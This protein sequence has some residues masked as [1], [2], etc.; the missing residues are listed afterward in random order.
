[1]RM[2]V[3]LGLGAALTVVL[4]MLACAAEQEPAGDSAESKVLARVGDEVITEAD[5]EAS[6][7]ALPR[8]QQA[9]FGSALGRRRF[10][11]QLVD[12]KLI[13]VGAAD[14]GLDQDETLQRRITA[15]RESLLRQAYHNYM[16]AAL[17]QP[18]EEDLRA[19][20]E[21]HRDEFRVLA[22]VN[23]S[24]IQCATREDAEAAR[25]RIVVQ[26]EHFGTVAREVTIDDC[27][28]RDNG[29]LGYFNPAGYIRCIGKREDFAAMA[30]ELE[31]DDV[32]PLFEWEDGW[33]FI[34]VHEKTTER[35]EPYSKARE[36]IVSR[37]RPTVT[38]SMLQAEL[39]SLRESIGVETFVD[40]TIDLEAKSA[41]E[42]MRLATESNSPLDK[43]EYYRALLRKYPHHERADEAQFMIGFVH[44]EELKDYGAARVEYQKVI[45]NY[46]QSNVRDSALWM[47]QNMG[48]DETPPF[49]EL[50]P[51]D[52]GT[53]SP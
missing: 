9:Q 4:G 11:N 24:W 29:L 47:L 51:P 28:R 3:R 48:R 46:P 33:A 49:E 27:S 6:L 14:K 38:D 8:H 36:R 2:R 13:V 37:L 39:V 34:K 18:T 12:Q 10:L 41:Q 15:F 19:Y 50:L 16:L 45:D 52:S 44:S 22:R 40:V 5:L 20:Y 32:G 53:D 25:H 7:N 31:A 35:P 30:F 43:I 23:A 1:M 26:G 17:P 42:L 21:A